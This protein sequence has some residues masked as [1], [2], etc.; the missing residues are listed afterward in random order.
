[1][2]PQVFSSRT[3]RE[4]GRVVQGGRRVGNQ[5]QVVEGLV[6]VELVPVG[7][8]VEAPEILR[9]SRLP[10]LQR[11]A[12]MPTDGLAEEGVNARVTDREAE[13]AEHPGLRTFG[14][15]DDA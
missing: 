9:L 13:V 7:E 2:A 6:D 8:I 14:R 5:D 15:A 1:M 3:R 11:H 10:A 4:I 12:A